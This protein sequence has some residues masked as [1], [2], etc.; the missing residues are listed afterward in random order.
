MKKEFRLLSDV[1]KIY[2]PP[3]YPYAVFGA[4]RMIKQTD[5]DD[6]VD[7]IPVADPNIHSLAQRVT[8]A[9]ENLK[10]AMS[11]PMLHNIREAYRRVYEALGTQDIDQ[12][13][14]PEPA[15]CKDP[16]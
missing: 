11:N 1:F 8:L 4:D 12:L 10:I 16:N 3:M 7:V 15:Q 2:L 9:N 13:L 6:R 14:I 5:F